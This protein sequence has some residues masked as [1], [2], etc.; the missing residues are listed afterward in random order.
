MLTT[1]NSPVQTVKTQAQLFQIVTAQQIQIVEVQP[2]W[3]KVNCA[4]FYII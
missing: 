2:V 3:M 1:M 4:C